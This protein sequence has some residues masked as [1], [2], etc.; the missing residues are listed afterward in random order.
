MGSVAN[1]TAGHRGSATSSASGGEL[2]ELLKG[3][4]LRRELALADHVDQLDACDGRRRCREAFKAEHRSHPALDEAVVLLGQIIEMFDS[5]H[6]DRD[7]AAEPLQHLVDVLDA[8]GVGSAFVDHDLTRQAVHLH[9]MSR[10]LDG[11]WLVSALRQHEG[12]SL[13]NLS[14]AR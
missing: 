9:C 7:R 5:H 10:K 12:Q 8:F 14:T 2:T 6:L 4:Q 3:T 11:C 13:P 1:R